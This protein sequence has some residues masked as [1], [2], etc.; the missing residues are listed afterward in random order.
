MTLQRDSIE[1]SLAQRGTRMGS[2]FQADTAD[3]GSLP[4]QRSEHLASQERVQHWWETDIDHL[5]SRPV[6]HYVA[7]AD[8]CVLLSE[9]VDVVKEKAALYVQKLSPRA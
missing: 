3:P 8:V 5:F 2:N 7:C 1:P 6:G 4:I 9:R